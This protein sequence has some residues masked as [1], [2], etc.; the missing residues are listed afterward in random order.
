MGQMSQILQDHGHN[1]T[2]LHQEG[3]NFYA[4]YLVI[5][6]FGFLSLGQ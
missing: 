4:R 5:V 1:M 6:T 3:L 2:M